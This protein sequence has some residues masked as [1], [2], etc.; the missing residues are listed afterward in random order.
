MSQK[1]VKCCVRIT[2]ILADI[3]RYPG[4]QSDASVRVTGDNLGPLGW[5]PFWQYNSPCPSDTVAADCQPLP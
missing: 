3:L 4:K 1:N 2:T 5:M